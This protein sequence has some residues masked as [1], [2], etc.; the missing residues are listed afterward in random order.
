[1]FSKK[2][3]IT[4]L[5]SFVLSVFFAHFA[6]AAP[7]YTIKVGT[8]VSETHPDYVT[9]RDVFKKKI[10]ENS[11]GAIKVELYP[12]SQLGGDREMVE[13]LQLGTLTMALPA[14]AALAGFEK[15]FQVLDLPYLFK[16]KEVAFK[17][18]DGELGKKLDALLPQH[19]IVNLAYSEN[20]FRHITNNR[21]PI[22]VP[23]D[24]KGL[25]IRTMENPMHIAFFKKLGANPTPMSYGEV[26]TAL[27]QKTI[28]GQENPIVIVLDGKFFEVQK[29]YSLTGHV[30]SAIM[31]IANK[32]FM[33]ALPKDLHAVVVKAA[34]DFSV[35][36]RKAVD[37]LEGKALAEMEKKG[38]QVNKVT[39]A[40]K[41]QFIKMALPIYDQFEGQLGKDI[42]DLAKKANK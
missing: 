35:A 37:T 22:H 6:F 21:K 11:K 31:L 30:F 18:L 16:S 42:I 40:E 39:A 14:S 29:Y 36:N 24:L 3:M 2:S 25:K 1:M 12:N 13:S 4:V 33:D 17:A 8:I 9:L 7:Q 34:K 20:G 38:L 15:K 32:P 27:Q 10:E 28:D 19:G 26:Y 41:E 5:L 23:A